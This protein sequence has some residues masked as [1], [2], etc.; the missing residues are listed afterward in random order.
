VRV[1]FRICDSSAVVLDGATGDAPVYRRVPVFY[2]RHQSVSVR[3]RYSQ[4][5]E[6]DGC[7][8]LTGDGPRSEERMRGCRLASR[9]GVLAFSGR[10]GDAAALKAKNGEFAGQRKWRNDILTG[11][12]LAVFL[13]RRLTILVQA[14]FKRNPSQPYPFIAYRC[15]KWRTRAETTQISANHTAHS[16]FRHVCCFVPNHLIGYLPRSAVFSHA[17]TCRPALPPLRIT[18]ASRR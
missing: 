9:T 17:C 12:M 1:Y 4:A 8:W 2:S 16:I 14:E 6:G 3:C 11:H 13:G 18:P 15:I 10:R 7:D 5:E